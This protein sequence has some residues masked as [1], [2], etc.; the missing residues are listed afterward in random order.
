MPADPQELPHKNN[1]SRLLSRGL[2][3]MI[4][5]IRE[6]ETISTH[7]GHENPRKRISRGVLKP[8][9]TTKLSTREIGEGQLGQPSE[10]DHHLSH[11]DTQGSFRST[12]YP[13]ASADQTTQPRIE[14]SGECQPP[15][16]ATTSEKSPRVV[17]RRDPGTHDFNLPDWF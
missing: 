13:G 14:C 7:S 2:F 3:T 17:S 11:T 15:P 16:L 1:K 6:T 12:G 10:G 5:R 4:V 9:E 8:V